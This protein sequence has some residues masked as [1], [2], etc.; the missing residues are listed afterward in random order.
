MKYVIET[1]GLTK[2]YGALKAVDNVSLHV[3]KGEIYGFLGLNGA[4]KT[5]A[6]RL[7]LGLARP[8][9]GKAFLNGQR[10]RPWGQGPWAQV[11]YLVEMPYA[12]PEL[13]VLENLQVIA[14]LRNIRVKQ[15]IDDIIGQLHLGPYQHVKSKNL[16]LGNAQ[17]LGL[18]KAL[19]H[20]PEILLLD[21]P[22]NGLDPAGIVEVREMLLALAREEGVTI[23][24]SSHILGEI[25]RLAT[26]IGIIH[27]GRLVQEIDAQQLEVLLQ[28][29]LVL[30]FR[31]MEKGLRVLREMGLAVRQGSEG[32]C[33][34]NQQ[35]AIQ[36][37][38]ELA[39][40][41]VDKGCPP[42]HLQVA[43]EDLESYFLRIIKQGHE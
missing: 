28:K 23:F 30:A 19:I 21:E 16:S 29:R 42:M 31:D 15:A 37:P 39:K 18:A 43:E 8:S 9:A 27:E 34:I 17:R 24:I 5:T 33:E 6:I 14:R 11:G 25:A 13:N 32:T 7:L 1:Q 22:A 12:Y 3:Q 10:I 36:F 2:R 4:G 40:K 20:R 35:E 41:L 26:R 38:D